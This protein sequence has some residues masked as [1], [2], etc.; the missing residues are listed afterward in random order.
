MKLSQKIIFIFFSLHTYNLYTAQANLEQNLS[1]VETTVNS[2]KE[3]LPL[4]YVPQFQDYSSYIPKPI[5]NI[6]GD[7]NLKNLQVEYDPDANVGAISAQTNLLGT[8][9]IVRI[10]VGQTLSSDTTFHE[11][12]KVKLKKYQNQLKSPAGAA[13]KST[14]WIKQGLTYVSPSTKKNKKDLINEGLK[15]KEAESKK[16]KTA[17]T[18]AQKTGSWI[19]NQLS[20]YQA[21]IL[22]ILPKGFKFASLSKD[23]S[24]LD[25]IDFEE[26]IFGISEGF[27]DPIYGSIPQGFS[28]IAKVNSGMEPFK[29]ITSFLNKIPGPA[30]LSLDEPFTLRGGITLGLGGSSFDFAL[31]GQITLN[32]AGKKIAETDQLGIDVMLL[33]FPEGSWGVS[34]LSAGL[35]G[36]LTLFLNAIDSRLNPLDFSVAFAFDSSVEVSISG[37][38]NGLL[39]LQAIGLPLEFGNITL[40]VGLN[41]ENIEILGLSELG[42]MGSIDF[43]PP[44]SKTD[45]T[46]AID[47]KVSGQ[48]TNILVY[49]DLE[50]VGRKKDALSL[51]DI[52]YLATAA[53]RSLSPDI[54]KFTSAIPDLGLKKASFYFSPRNTIFANKL[55]KA[56]LKVDIEVDIL[57][58]EAKLEC[59]I[60]ESGIDGTGFI[61]EVDLGPIKI[62]GAGETKKCV[63]KDFCLES[64]NNKTEGKQVSIRDPKAPKNI[65][66]AFKLTDS[67]APQ[68]LKDWTDY[69]QLKGPIINIKF[70]PPTDIGIFISGEIDVDIG[71]VGSFK[72]D[73]CFDISIGGIVVHFEVRAFNVFDTAF[74]FKAQEFSKPKDW[75]VC[76]ELKQDAL[77]LIQQQISALVQSAQKDLTPKINAAKSQ[78]DV[79]ERAYQ[80]AFRDAQSKINA[81]QD[82]VNSLKIELDEAKKYCTR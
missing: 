4:S 28:L 12:F 48:N 52:L 19:S 29:T 41:P 9:A 20:G 81:A 34:G 73:A 68:L 3:T 30:K 33:P 50:P 40:T 70:R 56:G 1:E 72:T 43:G 76:G 53:F 82:K 55:W 54:D 27:T 32:I 63:F 23:L 8:D 51:K 35:S 45:L 74:T 11:A 62:T 42:M 75:Y 46:A 38:M 66:D 77:T 18:F 17:P 36:G 64:C 6:L 2:G 44:D 47:V 58:V 7:I 21:G 49:G 37:I 10:M 5:T 80:D 22:L 26:I 61:S 60:D 57:G 71:K 24:F 13:K 79:A 65:T 31:P 78:V 69:S 25:F 67:T 14:T 16:T 59:D 15:A 39:N